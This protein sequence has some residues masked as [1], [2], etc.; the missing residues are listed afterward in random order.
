MN[1]G[2]NSSSVAILLV[3]LVLLYG[4]PLK[5]LMMTDF[6]LLIFVY[7]WRMNALDR[8]HDVHEEDDE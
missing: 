2:L 4:Y 6:V 7:V 5:N 3:L 1:Q 8:E